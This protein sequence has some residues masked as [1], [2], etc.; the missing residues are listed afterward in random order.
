MKYNNPIILSDYSD[1]DVIRYKS[2]Y[3]MV[4]SSFNHVPGI[5]VLK[6]KN[7]INWKQIGYVY[8]NL[9]FERF[10]NVCHGD[11]AWAPSLRYHNGFFY[12]IVSFYKEG[13]YVYS[14]TDIEKGD[15]SEPWCLYKGDN[16]EDPCPIW[17]E[18]FKT[19]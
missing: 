2:N 16:F 7:L 19:V 14:C 11:G 12:C 10:E 13:I 15:W 3:Y 5:P 6:S 18:G 9:P 17:Y 8:N 4:A 1:P